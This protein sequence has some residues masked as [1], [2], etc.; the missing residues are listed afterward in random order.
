M[1]RVLSPGGPQDRNGEPVPAI[2]ERSPTLPLHND[3]S[4]ETSSVASTEEDDFSEVS[5]WYRQGLRPSPLRNEYLRAPTLTPLVD[6]IDIFPKEIM[7]RLSTTFNG[8]PSL[9]QFG[10]TEVSKDKTPV[11]KLKW[12]EKESYDKIRQKCNLKIQTLK[13]RLTQNKPDRSF[14][15]YLRHGS[16]CVKGTNDQSSYDPDT[17]S[18]AMETMHEVA[19]KQICKFIA[20]FPNQSFELVIYC[21]YGSIQEKTA[22][23]TYRDLML[24]QYTEK[25]NISA[26]TVKDQHYISSADIDALTAP[27]ISDRLIDEAT[28]CG[29]DQDKKHLKDAVAH[30]PAQ[31]LLA[32]CVFERLSLRRFQHFLNVH[33]LSDSNLVWTKND[34]EDPD[35]CQVDHQRMENGAYMF[36]PHKIEEDRW[37]HERGSDEVVPISM[38]SDEMIGDGAFSEVWE[39]RIDIAQQVGQSLSSV[40]LIDLSPHSDY[41][42]LIYSRICLEPM[43]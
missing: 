42:V 2:I 35:V 27:E 40:S 29:N 16:C 25:L 8:K 36:F 33:K 15:V 21:D 24:V 38:V 30:R 37:F 18:F 7:C 4:P 28:D 1:D 32:V 6:D 41:Y 31:T 12:F 9:F 5:Q 3:P 39:V 11:P 22:G 43:R 20:T 14:R 13:D 34:C 26:K 10:A 23:E 19:I 17:S